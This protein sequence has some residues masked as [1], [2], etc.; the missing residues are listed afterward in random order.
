MVFDI[1][2]RS[3]K[4]IS[5]KCFDEEF[6]HLPSLVSIPKTAEHEAHRWRMSRRIGD[7]AQALG[8]VVLVDRYMMHVREARPCF[9]QAIGDGLRGKPSPMLDPAK[10]LL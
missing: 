7:L 6:G 8:A 9:V 4:V 2:G 1:V 5:G 3:A 10:P